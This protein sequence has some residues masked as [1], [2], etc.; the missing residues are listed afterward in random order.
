MQHNK[1]SSLQ[2]AS[3][4]TSIQW[5]PN[6]T[7]YF[8]VC[9]AS[10]QLCVLDKVREDPAPTTTEHTVHHTTEPLMYV[11]AVPLHN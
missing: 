9:F 7:Q 11:P 5:V 6:A 10:G 3:A 2:Q 8:I 4:V 1:G